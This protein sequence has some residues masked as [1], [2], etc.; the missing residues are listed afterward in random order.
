MARFLMFLPGIF[1]RGYMG[2]SI[3][4]DPQNGWFILENP[5]RMDDVGVPPFQETSTYGHG[6]IVVGLGQLSCFLCGDLP[7]KR[8]MQFDFDERRQ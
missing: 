4:G 6:P 8:G 2:T 1:D 7:T 3:N 5:I